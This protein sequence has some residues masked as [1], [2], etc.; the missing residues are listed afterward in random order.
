MKLKRILAI[1]GAVIVVVLFLTVCGYHYYTNNYSKLHLSP[2]MCGLM[3]DGSSPETFCETKGYGT[4]VEGKYLFAYVDHE[5]CLILTLKNDVIPEWKN[6]FMH[7]HV[8][9]CV[10]AD[11]RDIGIT[12]DY[13]KDFMYLMKYAY[14]CGYE[15]SEDFTKV[16][17]SPD[18]DS[19]YFPVIVAACAEMQI[20]EGKTCSETKVE[21]LEYDAAGK[22]IE[23]IVF[24]DDVGNALNEEK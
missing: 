8:M 11:S 22:L 5:G 17:K 13:S 23:K 20:F 18:D 9:Q 10:F 19:W 2:I 24:P 16:V 6:T 14:S 7:L 1:V 4:W 12:V 21:F 15:I 3:L